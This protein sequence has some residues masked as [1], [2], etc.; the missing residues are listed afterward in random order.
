MKSRPK[1]YTQGSFYTRV[2]DV[3]LNVVVLGYRVYIGETRKLVFK[4]GQRN[5][6]YYSI[7]GLKQ[8]HTMLEIG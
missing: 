5:P 4:V 7:F 6:I 8:N 1:S 3:K 2:Y